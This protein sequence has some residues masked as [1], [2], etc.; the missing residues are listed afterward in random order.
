MEFGCLAIPR[1][2]RALKGDVADLIQALCSKRA[3][4]FAVAVLVLWCLIVLSDAE[5]FVGVGSRP[6][7]SDAMHFV[8]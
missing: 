6:S 4:K 5:S 3:R 1:P 7:S 2:S 8:P